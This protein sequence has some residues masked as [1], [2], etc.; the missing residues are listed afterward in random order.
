[1][2][3]KRFIVSSFETNVYIVYDKSTKEGIVIDPS[4]FDKKVM[5]FIAEK[6]LKIKLILL[7]H[8]HFDHVTSAAAIKRE[9][10]A[11]ICI[12]P[13]DLAI[14]P[15]DKSGRARQIGYSFEMFEP[16]VHLYDGQNIR[17]GES[18]RFRRI[19]KLRARA[20]SYPRIDS[21]D[22]TVLHT[23]GHSPGGVCFY[24]PK[25]KVLFSGDTVFKNGYGRTDLVGGSEEQLF[26]SIKEKI[27]T[28]PNEVKIYSG[29]GEETS[30]A[31][32]MAFFENI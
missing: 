2:V 4:F 9:L 12:H 31:D 28:L 5:D 23:P 13:A 8:G 29:H 24:S 15:V 20:R 6:Q 25:E 1:M 27:L 16:D 17:V 30:V 19:P 10:N 32:E 18:S 14:M 11:Q 3:I 7:T 26:K 21:I 22:F